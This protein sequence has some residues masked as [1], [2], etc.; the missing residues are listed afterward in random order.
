M[1]RRGSFAGLVLAL[2]VALLALTS[3]ARCRRVE[4]RPNP[5][6]S[7]DALV[8]FAAVSLRDAFTTL[9]K[10]FEREYPGVQLSLH[11]AGTQ[12]LRAQ[13]EHGAPADVFASADQAHMQQLLAKKQ[14]VAP[15][16]FARNEPVLVIANSAKSTVR[17]FADLPKAER[18]VVGT[19]E[20]PIGRYTA[21]ILER[22]AQR[23]GAE[24]RAAV[25]ARIVSRELNV[26]QVLAKVILGEADVGIVYR[27]D[28]R[29]ARGGVSVV[30]IPA[31]LN[32]I[33][34]YPIALV[35]D[36]GHPKNG[37]KW[38]RLVTSAAGQQ[39]LQAAGFLAPGP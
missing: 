14:V 11:F 20:V 15:V 38:L 33:A 37:Q 24:F 28:S 8:V 12:E 7:E 4:P 23:F 9:G 26:R 3:L 29:A 5:T 18:I 34:N 1:P 22:A 31:E 36:A 16:V 35:A 6:A 13:L 27:T 32:L 21:Q 30:A 25:E 39:Q 10:Q 19:P 17:S 2:A